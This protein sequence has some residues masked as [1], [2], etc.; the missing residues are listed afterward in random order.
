[1]NSDQD[2][3]AR[4]ERWLKDDAAPMPAH[5]LEAVRSAV[6]RASQLGEPRFVVPRPW[7]RWSGRVALAAAAAILV[8]IGGPTAFGELRSILPWSS[9]AGPEIVVPSPSPSPFPEPTPTATYA[10]TPGP[11]VGADPFS[12]TWSTIDVDGSVTTLSFE[13]SGVTRTLVW[14]DLRATGCGGAHYIQAG[15]GTIAGLSLHVV[16]SGGCAGRP[17]DQPVDETWTYHPEAGTLT[18]PLVGIA[19]V[20]VYTWTRGDKVDAFSGVWVAT[21][22]D[23]SALTLTFGDSGMT[24]SAAFTDDRS[25]D[26]AGGAAYTASGTATIGSAFPTG[27]YVSVALHGSCA[28][29]GTAGD[30]VAG[31]GYDFVTGTLIGPLAAASD[32][33]SPLP[34]TVT[35]HRP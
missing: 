16:G 10:P 26:C 32:G 1:M 4:I 35:W 31:Y 3:E 14:E 27:R 11:S 22:V 15:S 30:T 17:L 21:D 28:G 12:E 29:G 34:T 19:G 13:G 2:I 18:S 5:V 25:G 20:D 33:A 9:D 8:V 7:G 23:G 6:P 24:R